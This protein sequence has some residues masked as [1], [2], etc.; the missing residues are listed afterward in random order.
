MVSHK[1]GAVMIDLIIAGVVGYI[2]GSFMTV[3]LIALLIKA[4][5][6]NG[7]NKHR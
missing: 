1:R 6:T 4:D 7:K 3:G 5:G 2:I